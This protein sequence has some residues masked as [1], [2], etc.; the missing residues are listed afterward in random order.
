VRQPAFLLQGYNLPIAYRAPARGVRASRYNHPDADR[1]GHFWHEDKLYGVVGL[2]YSFSWLTINSDSDNQRKFIYK[3]LG[4][5]L[6][7]VSYQFG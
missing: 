7:L 4:E 3:H 6:M 1:A 2:Q 5:K